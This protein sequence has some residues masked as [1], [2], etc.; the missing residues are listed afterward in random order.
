MKR[1]RTKPTGTLK[2][3]FLARGMPIQVVASGKQSPTGNKLK[4]SIS[5]IA[6]QIFAKAGGDAVESGAGDRAMPDRRSGARRTRF[7]PE[8]G[9]ETVF[10]HIRC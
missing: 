3:A 8:G 4:W 2:H 6:L 10:S 9:I 1:N 5:G 7:L